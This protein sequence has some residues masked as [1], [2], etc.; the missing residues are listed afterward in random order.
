MKKISWNMTR[1]SR[2]LRARGLKLGDGRVLLDLT[3]GRA[4]Y[5]RVD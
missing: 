3:V 4:L 1:Q 5:G 2:P